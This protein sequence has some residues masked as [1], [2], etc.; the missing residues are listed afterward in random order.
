MTITPNFCAEN[1]DLDK[2]LNISTVPACCAACNAD[3]VRALHT[4]ISLSHLMS[5]A[6][7]MVGMHCFCP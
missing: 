4:T 6:L 1:G 5:W 7:R 3:K 2:K